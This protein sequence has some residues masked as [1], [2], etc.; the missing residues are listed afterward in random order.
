VSDEKH[1]VVLQTLSRGIRALEL[2]AESDTPVS[3][4]DLAQ[5]LGLHRSIAYRVVRTLEEHR[6]VA[7]DSAG[8][9]KLGPSLA[10]LARNVDRD[11]Q[12]AALPELTQ[13]ANGL[14]MTAFLAVQDEDDAVTL[15]SVE[16]RAA[17]ATVAQRPGTR[18]SLDRGA[19]GRA[20]RRLVRR[21]KYD[22]PFE[23]SQDEV[24]QG[25][26]SI[27][28]PLDAPGQPAAAI[29]VVYLSAPVD[30]AAIGR[31]LADAAT[32]ICNEIR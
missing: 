29:A 13:L 24:I 19:P 15:L 23:T 3:I 20:V 17:L 5:R 28:V 30:V 2:L 7:R 4:S 10:S 31:H 14:G 32:A 18:H 8:D 26:S 1:G 12:T 16:P 25:L 11:L 22:L 9:L 27:A 21:G 6:L